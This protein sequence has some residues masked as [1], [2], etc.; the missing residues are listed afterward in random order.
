MTVRRISR[1]A[2]SLFSLR[3][4]YAKPEVHAIDAKNAAVPGLRYD[5]YL[6]SGC[7]HPGVENYE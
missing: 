1:S 2:F 7:G 4:L 3:N 5:F 6:I